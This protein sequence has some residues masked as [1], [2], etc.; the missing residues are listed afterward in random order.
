[1]EL[2]ATL[3]SKDS[4]TQELAAT[5]QDLDA[6]KQDLDVAKQELAASQ[7]AELKRVKVIS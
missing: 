3:S 7:T 5:K 2:R 6:A 4:E 1:M